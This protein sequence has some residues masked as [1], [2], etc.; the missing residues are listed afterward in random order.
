MRDKAGKSRGFGFVQFETED[1]LKEAYRRAD[2]RK[3][4]GRRLVCNP[5]PFGVVAG[6][7][8]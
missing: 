5:T 6:L 1:Q 7:L 2:G 8:N 3:V 4:D